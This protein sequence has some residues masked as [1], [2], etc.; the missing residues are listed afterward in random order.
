M[1]KN[2]SGVG[3]FLFGGLLGAAVALLF[4]PRTGRETRRYLS[5]KA[6]DYWENADEV[7]ENGRD[8]AVE[9]YATGREAAGAA[10]DQIRTKIDEARERLLKQVEG[11]ESEYDD[12]IAAEAEMGHKYPSSV[13]FVSEVVVPA[14]DSADMMVDAE[15]AS[16]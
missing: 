6:L 1:S 4:T 13:K 5:D 12:F 9:I 3:S 11:A 2:S 14:A 8:R 7:Y 15:P 10:S 16:S